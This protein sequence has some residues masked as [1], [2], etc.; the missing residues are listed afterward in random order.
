MNKFLQAQLFAIHNENNGDGSDL[1]AADGGQQQETKPATSV[2]GAAGEQQNNAD[3][4]G[5]NSGTGAESDKPDYGTLPENEDGYNVEIE[6]FDFAEFKADEANKGFIKAAHAHG[7]T[8][9]QM[10]FILT[11]YNSRAS[12]LVESAAALDKDSCIAVLK[13]EWGADTEKN[14]GL[15]Y[16]AAKAAGFT[17]EQINDPSFGNNPAVV[18]L[19]AYFGAQLGEDTPPA[20]TQPTSSEDIESL[21]LSDAYNDPKHADYKRVQAKVAQ[22]FERLNR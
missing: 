5:G 14:Q 10:S 13:E 7:I 21:M 12:E 6:N 3:G 19:A 9:K 8:D 17:D 18:K 22:H 1:P 4:D 15:A 2:L 11:E 16:R 20:N